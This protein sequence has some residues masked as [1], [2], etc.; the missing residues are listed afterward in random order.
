MSTERFLLRHVDSGRP[1]SN[2]DGP[3]L[4]ASRADALAAILR[5]VCEPDAYVVAVSADDVLCEAS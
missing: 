5:F 3:V 1:W 2:H 4:F